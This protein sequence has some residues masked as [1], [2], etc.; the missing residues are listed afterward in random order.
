MTGHSILILPA[1][2]ALLYVAAAWL[3]KGA[4]G[5]GASSGQVNLVVNVIAGLIAQPAWVF[6]SQIDWSKL[7]MPAI[8]AVTFS[9]GQIFTFMALRHGS[10]SVATPLLGLKVVFVTLLAAIFFGTVLELKWWIAAAACSL[11][12]IL[13]TGATPRALF[14]RLAQPDAMASIAA[15]FVFALTDLFVHRWAAE[16]GTAAFLALMFGLV[17]LFSAAA[18]PFVGATPSLKIPR[19]AIGFLLIGSII[20][21]VQMILMQ[22][23]LALYGNATAVNIIY[24]AR[25]VFSVIVALALASLLRI[26]DDG[27]PAAPLSRRLIGSLLVF[28]SVSAALL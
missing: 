10:V 23:A 14:S 20:L 22:I 12:V 16:F 19:R 5:R 9:F 24:S 13:V 18:F 17:G 27:T 3:I 15:A 21:G 28:G 2:A 4:I 6:V 26:H 7:W 11:G 1:V 8:A 25:A